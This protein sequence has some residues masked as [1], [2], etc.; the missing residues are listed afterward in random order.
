LRVRLVVKG[1]ARRPCMGRESELAQ[2]FRF[3]FVG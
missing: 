3:A 2:D 1:I